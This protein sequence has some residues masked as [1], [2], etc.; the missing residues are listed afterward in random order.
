MILKSS[1]AP[2]ERLNEVD[3]AARLGIS[4]GPLRE[5]LQGLAAEGLEQWFLI[6]VHSS[7]HSP[8]RTF[9]SYTR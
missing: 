8:L 4:R 1:F 7:A 6:R 2:G 3:L 9:L 5:A